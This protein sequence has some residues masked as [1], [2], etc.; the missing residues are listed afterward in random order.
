LLPHRQQPQPQPQPQPYAAPPP[1]AG[2]PPAAPPVDYAKLPAQPTSPYAT[3]QA[4]PPPAAQNEQAL[5]LVRA[6]IAA[7]YADGT[8][9]DAERADILSRLD[10]AGVAA[11]ERE[12]FLR[13]LAS[14][15][16]V[17]ALAAE[18]KSPEMAE[19]FYVVSLLAMKI[20]NDAE[21]AYASM[22]PALLRLSP[23]QVTAIHQTAGLPAVA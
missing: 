14:P 1:A 19:Q 20:D 12:M 18:V 9:D 13:E 11:A 22:L 4:G 10:G 16:P 8:I 3:Q 5:L 6:M 17:T 23:E 7:A 21:R 15:K 2:V